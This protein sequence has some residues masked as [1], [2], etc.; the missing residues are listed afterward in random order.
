M[1]TSPFPSMLAYAFSQTITRIFAFLGMYL[2]L[3]SHF[4]KKK[5]HFRLLGIAGFCPDPF[6]PSGMLSTLGMP[7]AL[8]ALLN[9]EWEVFLEGMGHAYSVTVLF[10]LC[11]RIFLL[12]IFHGIIMAKRFAR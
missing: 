6:W 1:A 5:G 7:L 12:L 2:L 4:I 11:V 3:K 10:E 9:I 8:W